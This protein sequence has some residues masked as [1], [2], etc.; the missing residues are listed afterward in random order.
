MFWIYA[1]NIKFLMWADELTNICYG[2]V[3]H[4]SRSRNIRNKSPM[5]PRTSRW[6]KLMH[7][8]VKKPQWSVGFPSH[9]TYSKMYVHQSLNLLGYFEAQLLNLFKPYR[10]SLTQITRHHGFTGLQFL[11]SDGF[12][13]WTLLNIGFIVWTVV[14]I[15]AEQLLLQSGLHALF[16][17]FPY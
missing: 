2:M 4:I 8:W 17:H 1:L 16:L 13:L 5:V 6:N 12:H 9:C 11:D 14:L 3:K 15:T 10:K 7:Q